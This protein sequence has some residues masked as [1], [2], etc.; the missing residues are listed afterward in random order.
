MSAQ[1]EETGLRAHMFLHS[2][3]LSLSLYE[4][5]EAIPALVLLHLIFSDTNIFT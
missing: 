4:I 2:E 1:I 3:I 5:L